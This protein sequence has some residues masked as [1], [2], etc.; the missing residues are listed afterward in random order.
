VSISQTTTIEYKGNDKDEE[1]GGLR[2][3]YCGCPTLLVHFARGWEAKARAAKG[4]NL[5]K[6]TLSNDCTRCLPP[7]LHK[8]REGWGTL[9]PGGA[10][11]GFAI[12]RGGLGQM[13]EETMSKSLWSY[14]DPLSMVVIALTLVLFVIALFVNGFT[15]ELLQ[16]CGVF[17]VSVKLI[18][19]SHKNGVLAK[20]AEE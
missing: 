8:L 19:I 14:F 13:K 6:P 1:R 3:G 9:D 17:L 18:M 15:H 5:R 16:E 4:L 20:H 11:E 12:M 10:R 2:R 7:T